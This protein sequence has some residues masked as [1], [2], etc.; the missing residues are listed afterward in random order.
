MAGHIHC[1]FSSSGGRCL[2]SLND[3][4]HGHGHGRNPEHGRVNA[5]ANGRGHD[6]VRHYGRCGCGC[7]RG[8]GV[9]PCNHSA[10]SN[11][12]A[13]VT[14]NSHHANARVSE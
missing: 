12:H 5:R 1:L 10:E 13:C 6:G 3:R 11:V 14:V 2:Q 8:R 9:R 7:G 4:G